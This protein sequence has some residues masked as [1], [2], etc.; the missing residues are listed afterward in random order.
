M[1]TP[2]RVLVVDDDVP[3]RI[4]LRSI[5]EADDTIVVVAE[6][7]DAADA[8]AKASELRPDIVLMD[9]Q[10]RG[11]DGITATEQI[12]AKPVDGDATPRVIVLT[13]FELDDLAY[14]SL[15]AGASGFLLKRTRAE[16]I[17]EAVHTV[18]E[19]TA[20]P[21]P[22]MARELIG[23]FATTTHRTSVTDVLTE[24]ECEVLLFIARG[25]SNQ[26][27]GA[28]LN[29]RLDT[30]KSHIKH[31]FNKLGVRDRA[32]AVIAAYESGLVSPGVG[33]LDAAQSPSMGIS[34]RTQ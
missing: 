21:F 20:L 30:V 29:I 10:L 15:R 25:Y 3:T 4:G 17:V 6:S 26:E 2:I 31:V 22:S 23:H 14:R 16:D 32:Q 19:G 34:A 5:L 11:A 33:V 13:T 1:P 8:V 12:L 7:A 18:A 24:R 28:Q 27:I 9:V